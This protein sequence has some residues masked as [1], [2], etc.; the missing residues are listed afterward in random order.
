MQHPENNDDYL[1]QQFEK[2]IENK[3]ERKVNLLRNH[4]HLFLFNGESFRY[5]ESFIQP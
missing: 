5:K 1:L 3:E 2:E 4:S